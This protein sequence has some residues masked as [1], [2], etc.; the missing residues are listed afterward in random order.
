[1]WA[2]LV[3]APHIFAHF[4]TAPPVADQQ[5][6]FVEEHPKFALQ[7]VRPRKLQ[8]SEQLSDALKH[9]MNNFLLNAYFGRS[10][11]A[12]QWQ[13]AVES[14]LSAPDPV[15]KIPHPILRPKWEPSPF[16][17][18]LVTKQGVPLDVNGLLVLPDQEVLWTVGEFGEDSPP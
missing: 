1:M 6:S 16:I 14:T 15:A 13:V 8:H 3:R 7:C 9:M 17:K 10:A 12:R 5:N 4:G 2:R 11:A 18:Q